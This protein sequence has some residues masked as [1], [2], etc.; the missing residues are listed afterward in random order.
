MRLE[1][2]TEDRVS[3]DGSKPLAVG[4]ND[5]LG[6]FGTTG[7]ATIAAYA[8][9]PSGDPSCQLRTAVCSSV[10]SGT[11]PGRGTDPALG[12]GRLVVDSD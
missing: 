8:A 2:V 4:M 9:P 6:L 11:G 1:S 5:P 10:T 3:L 7:P 12:A